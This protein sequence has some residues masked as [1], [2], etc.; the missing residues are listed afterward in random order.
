MAR[1]MG[2]DRSAKRAAAIIG[3]LAMLLGASASA[4][5]VSVAD[6][7]A[8]MRALGF[9][10]AL[11]NR[12]TITVGVVYAGG[13]ADSKALAGRTAAMLTRLKGPGSSTVS[14]NVVAV[15]ELSQNAVHVDALYLMPL[16]ADGG[17][18]VSE[19]VK[20]Q[21]VVSISNDPGCMET[22]ACVLLVQAR[23]NMSIVLDTALAQAADVKFSTVFTMLVKRR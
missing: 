15:Q 20:R 18:T 17:H 16:P 12:S 5:E 3:V 9:L 19:F 6:L 2:Q 14:A 11:Q 1:L 4:A 7:Q 13:D 22:R 23:S 21:S 8:A 10:T